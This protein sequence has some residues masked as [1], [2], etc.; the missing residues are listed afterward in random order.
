MIQPLHCMYQI[1]C[2]HVLPECILLIS[3]TRLR[4]ICMFCHV[5][6]D[7]VITLPPMLYSQPAY[8]MWSKRHVIIQWEHGSYS[9]K[10]FI[11][12]QVYECH[13]SAECS[14]RLLVRIKNLR[15]KYKQ[16]ARHRE[17]CTFLL[18]L[19]VASSV[20]C[21][22]KEITAHWLCMHNNLW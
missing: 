14:D 7:D 20:D 9:R 12:Y 16:H 2:T 15:Q 1:A 18:V 19:E 22:Q 17:T 6:L 10:S 13:F 11:I 8:E 5:E 21:K 3:Q 4:H